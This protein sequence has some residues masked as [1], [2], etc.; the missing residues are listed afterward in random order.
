[1]SF[2]DY[3][4][5]LGGAISEPIVLLYVLGGIFARNYIKLSWMNTKYA[6]LFLGTILTVIY[7]LLNKDVPLH[8]VVLSYA[9]AT[10]MYEILLK[11]LLQKIGIISKDSISL[12][13]E[14]LCEQ[15]PLIGLDGF[16]SA[17]EVGS[18]D[19]NEPINPDVLIYCNEYLYV[20]TKNDMGGI[21]LT[22]NYI[23]GKPPRK[24]IKTAE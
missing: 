8:V 15:C 18:I 7:A 24:P 2:F 1:M 21:E 17:K 14:P 3:D 23:G 10:T 4:L 11:K 20:P 9:L 6:T 22:S 19:E 12:A 16:Y 13:T 5:T